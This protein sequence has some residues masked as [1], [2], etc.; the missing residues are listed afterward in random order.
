MECCQG[1]TSDAWNKEDMMLV[2]PRNVKIW[3]GGVN[4][5]GRGGGETDLRN[6]KVEREAIRIRK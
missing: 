3:H 4:K 5:D 6:D 1:T 2:I